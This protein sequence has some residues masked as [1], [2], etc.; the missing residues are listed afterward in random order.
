MK[1]ILILLLALITVFSFIS[2]DKEE[3]ADG[4]GE[5]DQ[6]AE[7]GNQ[8]GEQS[9]KVTYTVKVL[10]GTTGVQGVQISIVNVM[11]GR[12][13]L[14]TTDASGTATYTADEGIYNASIFSAPG[15]DE[16][17]KT[18]KPFG[19][20]NTLTFILST[21]EEEEKIAYTIYV[22][23][24]AG[25]PVVGL[26]VQ[27]CDDVCRMPVVTDS[28]GRAVDYAP[29]GGWRAQITGQDGVYHSFDAN[30]TVTI[31]YDGE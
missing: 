10:D 15:Y 9:R 27:I 18:A 16:F 4:E 11:D 29:E 23:D 8:G 20:D 1:K 22:K 2:C 14:V 21:E 6:Q 25:N 26:N 7:N 28:E 24:S 19:A 31:I 12:K 30:N 13:K 5:N 17:D 3:G